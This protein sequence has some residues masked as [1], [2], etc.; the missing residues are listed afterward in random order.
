[1]STDGL[2][3]DKTEPHPWGKKLHLALWQLAG[4]PAWAPALLG[5]EPWDCPAGAAR[6]FYC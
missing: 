3:D 4:R 2:W 5:Y 6:L 1:M